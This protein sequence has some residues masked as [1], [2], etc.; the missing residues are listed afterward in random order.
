MP[1][2][3]S[4]APAETTPRS[5]A[6]RL[7]GYAGGLL[8]TAVALA[9][10]VLLVVRHA[11]LPWVQSLGPDIADRLSRTL[12]VPVAI[13]RLETGW[14][15]WNPRIAVEGLTV[16]DRAGEG[17]RTLLALPRV[18]A[19]VSW[20]SLPL[21]ELRL[22][23]LVVER[24][25]LAIARRPD[26]RLSVAGLEIDPD[27]PA[28]DA[29]PVGDW[30]LRQREVVVR[31]ALIVWT[32]E[33]RG[34]PPLVLDRVHFRLEHPL[35][36]RRHRF[37][38]AGVPPPE[39]A[40]PIDLR[41]EVDGASARDPTQIEGRIYLRFDYADVAALTEWAPLP[42]PVDEGR[43]ALR[44]WLDFGGGAVRD[45]HADL[46]LVD[47]KARLATEL[48]RLELARV[49]GRVD[50]HGDAATRRLAARDLTLVARDGT[51]MP[52]VDFSFEGSV[53]TDGRFRS[54]RANVNAV[55]LAPLAALATRIPMPPAWRD[56]LVA[57]AP[58]GTLKDA[59][60]RWEGPADAPTS[61][62]LAGEAL[63][64]VVQ[65]A[66]TTPG[67]SGLSARIEAD[68]RGG[69]AKLASKSVELKLPA[70]FAQPLALDSLTGQVRWTRVPDGWRV[71]LVDLGY[72][73]ADAA[74]IAEGSWRSS[75]GGPGT[76]DLRA[77]L[78]RADARAV[79]RYL[80]ARFDPGVREWIRLGVLAGHADDVRIVLKGD[81][82]KFPYADPRDGTFSV[83]AHAKG[84]A[85]DYADGW[86]KVEDIDAE[87]RI[88][89]PRIAGDL[90]HARVYGT[91][92]G[93][94]SVSI[95]NLLAEAPVLAIDGEASGPTADVLRFI[96]ASPVGGWIGRAT[97]GTQA[98]GS[99]RLKLR[100]AL[101]LGRAKET[102]VAGEYT[103]ASNQLRLAGLPTL[104][105]VDGR[106]AFSERGVT[107]NDIAAE[108]YGGPARLSVAT[109]GDGIRVSGHG[110]ADV[111]ALR[112][113]LPAAI[114]DRFSGTTDWRLAL[115]AGGATG[116]RWTVESALKG[117]AIDLP[118][119]LGKA[120]AA[121]A[122]LTIERRPDPRA[123]SDAVDFSL[124]GVGR[125][126]VHRQLAGTE[127][128]VDRVLVLLGRAA[129]QQGDNDRTGVWVRGDLPSFALDDWLALRAHAGA[130]STSPAASASAVPALMGVDIDALV[131][132]AFGRKLNDA[133]V[134]ARSTGNDW[135]ITLTA[136][137]MAGSAIWRAATPSMPS[138]RVTARL[139]RLS[140][141]ETGEL[142]PWT[143]GDSGSPS[144]PAAPERSPWPEI[145]VHSDRLLTRGRDLGDFELVAKPEGNDWRIERM[146]LANDAGRIRAEGAWRTAGRTQRTRL[147]VRLEATEASAM[148]RRF[149]FPDDLK[150]A[151][152]TIAG[153]LDWPGAP[154][155]F[156]PSLLS[157]TLRIDVG[158]GQFTKIEPGLGKLLGVLSLQALPRRISL[159]F[160]DVFSEGF[161]FDR[162]E[163]GVKI[164]RGVMTTERLVLSGPAAKVDITGDVD[165]TTE[166]QRL[167]V[168]VQP[169]LSTTFSAGTAGA[170]LLLAAA[171]PLVAA[172]VGAGTF[173]AQKVAKDPIEQMFSYE[174][175]VSGSWSAP[176][177]ARGGAAGAGPLSTRAA[178]E[179]VTSPSLPS[180]G[181]L[182]TPEPEPASTPAPG[183]VK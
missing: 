37:G 82:A 157:G 132:E 29:S 120:A 105:A 183:A 11:V 31:D 76:I 130:R 160:R 35:G 80:P 148:L 5:L 142:V 41:G 44:L 43:G 77:K 101:P 168:R 154:S 85:L 149:G 162:I 102:T 72:A 90:A 49:A 64:I 20:W 95:D 93:R 21:A 128:V 141:P 131:L 106:L 39:L 143:G 68:E 161:A 127:P 104:N 174:Y 22:K 100:I 163:G 16:R 67:V 69:T 129:A 125:A 134:S 181:P 79:A 81:L 4:S 7:A 15:G 165:L 114:A 19:T 121:T 116:A 54:G 156:E 172:V 48:P 169:A 138:G 136:R 175:R 24:P 180:I 56:G 1:A 135:R 179:P 99:G 88:T 173:L 65:A 158:A 117:T 9:C 166:T 126:Q 97:E 159:D 45:M 147:D 145:D 57:R 12:G 10:V 14:D 112:G 17:A 155:D 51:S 110:T 66:G 144:A 74:G 42:V 34:A 167:V 103:F 2:E 96:D 150:G 26:G 63:D 61:Y 137:E 84:G 8:V 92:I 53:G 40:S 46:E 124:A 6:T 152:T 60:Y 178:S 122:S 30:L 78:T 62:S 133:K 108:V 32:D 170:A 119:P 28:A 47:V 177:V 146:V 140:V 86:P 75:P 107:A 115:E 52:P 171:N 27:A 18:L 182:P 153:E 33:L 118:A 91:Q 59:R 164:V 94:T 113:E 71:D 151:P 89:G 123:K 23:E 87:I 58:G 98:T 38:L 70:V 111:A 50:W 73:N 55:A 109:G 13:E 139:S 25:E 83:T 3:S 36:S 176:V